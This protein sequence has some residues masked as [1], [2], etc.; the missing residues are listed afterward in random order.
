MF[1]QLKKDIKV[2]DRVKIYL[3]TGKE[4]VGIVLEIGESFILIQSE[5]GSQN[6]FFDKLIGGWEIVGRSTS[7]DEMERTIRLGQVLR[8]L[9]VGYNDISALLKDGLGVDIEN[10]PNTKISAKEFAFLASQLQNTGDDV[11]IP[12]LES[13]IK[14]EIDKEDKTAPKSDSALWRLFNITKGFNIK[15]KQIANTRI[16]LGIPDSELRKVKS[17][18]DVT[19]QVNVEDKGKENEID[20]NQKSFKS[21]DELKQLMNETKLKEYI[22]PNA[23]INRFFIQFSNGSAKNDEVAEIRFKNEVVYDSEL[24]NELKSF[25]KGQTIPIIC[26]YVVSNG[27]AYAHFVHKPDTVENLI[28]KA[29]QLVQKDSFE[30][31]SKLI[32]HLK[33]NKIDLP[34]L[35]ELK[36]QIDQKSKNHTTPVNKELTKQIIQLNEDDLDVVYENARKLRLRK[37]FEESEKLFLLLAER[38]YQI[39]SVVKDLADQYREQGRLA[40]AIKLME[41]YFTKF[42]KKDQGY[43]FLYDLYVNNGELLKAKSILEEIVKSP[44][45][46]TDKIL[47]KRRGRAYARLGALSIKLGEIDKAEQYFKRSQELSPDNKFIKHAFGQVHTKAYQNVESNK[48]DFFDE[49]LFDNLLFGISP[50][51]QYA[52]EN[53]SY[54]GLPLSDKEKGKFTN[55]TLR[56]LRDLISKSKSGRPDVRAKYYLTEAKLLQDLERSDE[57]EFFDALANYCNAM[58]KVML[59]ERGP[60]ETVRDYYLNSFN[61]QENGET[62]GSDISLFFETFYRSQGEVATS[63]GVELTKALSSIT[64][65]VYRSDDFWN[66]VTNAI[67]NSRK[68]TARILKIIYG[69]IHLRKAGVVYLN[70]QLDLKLIE[71]SVTKE[72]FINSWK[73]V[74]KNRKKERE[75]F[76]FELRGFLKMQ[77]VEEFTSVFLEKTFQ[78]IP[79]FLFPLDRNRLEILRSIGDLSQQ[80]LNQFSFDDREF[81]FN[82][83]ET[84]YTETLIDIEK[85][86]TSFSIS[87][88]LPLLTHLFGLIKH[89][90]IEIA[91]ASKPV[92]ELSVEGENIVDKEGNCEI[93]ISISNKQH[94]SK[95]G[96]IRLEIVDLNQ[97]I[98]G[99][100]TMVTFSQ[101]L[102]GGGEPLIGRFLLKLPT[103]IINQGAIDIKASCSFKELVSEELVNITKDLSISFFDSTQFIEIN[104]PYAEH[105]KSNIV[106]NPKMFKGRDELINRVCTTILSSKSKGYVVYGQK[107]SGKSSVLWH[108]ENSLNKSNEAF[109]VYFSIGL[110][111]AQD[112]DVE[113]NLYYTILTTIERKLRKLKLEGQIVPEVGKTVR[114]ELLSSPTIFFYD[115]L[116]EI[117]EA[118]LLLDGWKSKKLVLIVDEFTYIYYQ[119]KRGNIPTTFM[120]NWKAFVEDGG[121]SVILSGQDSMTKFMAEFQNEFAMFKTERLTYLEPKSARELIEEPVWDEVNNRS[122]YTRNSVGKI[123][124]LTACSPFYIQIVCNELVRFMNSK[125]KPVLTP[126]DVDDVIEMLTIGSSSLTEFDFENLLSAGDKNLDKI[127]PDEAKFILNEIAKQTK[128]LKYCRRDE[129]NVFGKEKDDEIIN[130]LLKRS[131]ISEEPEHPNKFKIEVQLFKEWLL[132]HN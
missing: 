126:A 38:N 114:S 85:Y 40:D 88:I 28:I 12:E 118:F 23:E 2:G 9:N 33:K 31:A 113:T 108:L 66:Y 127:K 83:I 64:T 6:R 124:D 99:I 74:S 65:Q 11:I 55:Q 130:D 91:K 103:S 34:A 14:E 18:P 15:R 119:I 27:K 101:N 60:I 10:N 96:E 35:N 50:F 100:R 87:S 54:E 76:E 79:E 53:C 90:Q 46:T 89:K 109:A 8:K 52:L 123:V 81:Y 37:Q 36:G 42:E 107:R 3:T 92:V 80:Y 7:T 82:N 16:R 104:N 24:L 30:G 67:I 59:A 56:E 47:S 78:H 58:A 62:S 75:E 97:E 93:Q 86:P 5:D 105:A 4:P 21:F 25:Q 57:N 49:N 44:F 84:R 73:A 69:T 29:R 63:S 43:N 95:I 129:I 131:V 111:I 39:D 94:C 117:K 19:N 102:R 51:L 98:G 120:L 106:E 121:F 116:N 125:R 32:A 71:S 20:I 115:R 22:S 72:Q 70:K 13:F 61:I 17:E 45:D 110:S 48:D 41:R 26:N 112:D 128:F 132:N 1:D 122:R 68:A 77:N